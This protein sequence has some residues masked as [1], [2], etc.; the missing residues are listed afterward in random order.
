MAVYFCLVYHKYSIN[1]CFLNNFS[2]KANS[3]EILMIARD[4]SIQTRLKTTK[5]KTQQST[6][7]MQIRTIQNVCVTFVIN[8]PVIVFI[9]LKLL[10]CNIYDFYTFK[11]IQ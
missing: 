9:K 11:Y 10:A 8:Y 2:Y 1:S 7:K 3:N 5:S 6:N 4:V